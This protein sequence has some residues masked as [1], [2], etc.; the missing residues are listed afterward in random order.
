MSRTGL[1]MAGCQLAWSGQKVP[2]GSEDGILTAK[3]IAG[4]DL[5]TV[6]CAVLSACETGNGDITGDGV[7]GLQRGFKQ[8]GVKTLM[9]S[10]WPVSDSATQLLMT[11][12]YRRWKNGSSK[13][14]ALRQ[15]QHVVRERFE[16]P[17]YW[18]AFILLD[19]LEED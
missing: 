8:A 9:M 3:E 13:R 4:L 11:E 15:A 1:L 14:E 19:A 5:R 2:E 6:D 18:A 17:V 10:L 7:A 12:F 16:E